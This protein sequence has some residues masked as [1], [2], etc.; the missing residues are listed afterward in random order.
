MSTCQ[1]LVDKYQAWLDNGP[2]PLDEVYFRMDGRDWTYR[3][4]F[5]S[6]ISGLGE[7]IPHE[8]KAKVQD[9]A[10][11]KAI[12]LVDGGMRIF[13]AAK[14]ARVS[15]KKLRAALT[16]RKFMAEAAARRRS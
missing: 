15:D 10:I 12:A 14:R 13:K 2:Y 4:F 5:R 9:A 16:V 11:E 3:E 7:L 6:Q 1:Q 8:P